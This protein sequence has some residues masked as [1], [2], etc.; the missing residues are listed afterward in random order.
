MSSNE[1]ITINIINTINNIFDNLFS[2]ID[3]NLY[4]ELDKLVFVNPELLMI[5]FL[6][7]YLEQVLKMECC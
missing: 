5:G 6:A 1:E 4:R 7:K 2:S 3:T